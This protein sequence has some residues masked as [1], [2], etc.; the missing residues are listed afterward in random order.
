MSSDES[1]TAGGW[2]AAGDFLGSILAGLFLGLGADALFNTDPWL[3]VTGIITG[4]YAGFHRMLV[5]GRRLDEQAADALR[6]KH[7]E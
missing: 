4:S 3:V 7:G 6:A 5:V 1:A 2:A